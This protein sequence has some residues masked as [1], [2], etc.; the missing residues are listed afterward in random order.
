MKPDPGARRPSPRRFHAPL[1]RALVRPLRSRTLWW[2]VAGAALLMVVALVLFRRPL[3]EWLWP[4]TRIQQ[5]LAQAER[6]LGQGRLSAPDGSGAR[7]LFEAALALDSDRGEARDGLARTGEAALGQARRAL[8]RDD[9]EA[10]KQ[11]LALARV[12]Q[13]PQ[14]RA[15]ALAQA[16]LRQERTHAGIDELVAR[17]ARA[18]AEGRLD[19]EP[20]GALPLYRRVL[21]LA[22]ERLDAL[23]GREDALSDLLQQVRQALRQDELALA[24][25]QL[26]AARGYDPGHVD[27]PATEAAFN[28]AVQAR[29]RRAETRLRQGRLAP[30]AEDLAVLAAL[31]PDD[32]RI[33]RGSERLA[34]ALAAEAVRR[35]GDFDF[36]AA[37][38]ALRRARALA[39]AA[40]S[41]RGAEQ[42]VARARQ[43]QAS[44]HPSLSPAQ[45]ARRLRQL[46]A[47]LEAAEAQQ[48][49]VTPPGASAYD[50]LR[51]AQ[52]LAP[53][54]PRVRSAVARIVPKT[55]ECF[56]DALRANRV[57][58]AQACLEAW[59]LLA[60][61]DAGLADARQRLAE[62]WIAVGSERLGA[63]DAD[64]ASEAA[65]QARQ[66]YPQAPAL[67]DFDARIR[68][69]ERRGR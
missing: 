42:A 1:R 31:R 24:A 51:E 11:A 62:R 41:L 37:D 55:R 61:Q 65:R 43:L 5:R 64:F 39:P 57:R 46:L 54:D 40:A 48:H 7:E 49:W 28:D 47:R 27:L 8:A 56:E 3:G 12:L 17:A 15:D 53:R 66:L 10:A 35:A 20:D 38:D 21:E 14:A 22:P 16:I 34:D 6:A 9:L 68:A 67:A 4:D 36:D 13:V 30:A 32:P 69:V 58:G 2:G 52:A 44:Q 50:A 33:L 59:Q 18:R 23:E 60:A 25:A 45:Q 26:A 63:G 19:S 29:L